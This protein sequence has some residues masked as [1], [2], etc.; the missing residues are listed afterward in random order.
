MLDNTDGENVF[1]HGNNRHLSDAEE[2]ISH[3]V[4]H[5]AHLKIGENLT[6][7]IT[8][9]L[10]NQEADILAGKNIIINAKELNNTREGKDIDITL[11]FSRTY[12]QRGGSWHH[13]KTE[14]HDH[15]VL[16]PYKQTLYPD[17]PTQIIAGG[18]LTIN[19]KEV[20]NGEY[21][22]HKSGYI[23]DVKKSRKR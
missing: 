21:Q 14:Y 8:N 16:K 11:K 18:N 13:H 9:R 23:N 10:L 5:K 12:S 17:K 15:W 7:N 20:G 1:W 4:A 2:G 19:A 22:D 6:F 3:Y